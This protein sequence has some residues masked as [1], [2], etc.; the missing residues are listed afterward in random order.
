MAHLVTDLLELYKTYFQKPYDIPQRV[1]LDTSGTRFDAP[2]KEQYKGI[3]VF[4]PIRMSNGDAEV[5]IPC[6]TIR[7]TGQKTII[8]TA[9]SE[10]KGTVKEQFN[11][12][13][14][15]FNIKG[16]LIAEPG[17]AAPD[18]DMYRLRMLFES[19]EPVE[20]INAISDLFMDENRNVTIT[21][22]EFPDVE[23]K[24]LRCR[25]FTLTCESDSVTNLIQEA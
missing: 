15:Q 5:Y 6:A 19:T 20:L 24:E 7:V 23:G 8:R 11:I 21:D 13:D 9:V 3:P 18:D 2:F 25:P 22:M 1:E 17:K 4:L 14:Y 10:R 16:V 12:G